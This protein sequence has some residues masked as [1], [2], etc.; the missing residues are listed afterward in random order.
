[1]DTY[2][3]PAT[4]VVPP[5]RETRYEEDLADGLL[6]ADEETFA[7]I[8]RRWGSLVHTMATRSLGD[9]HEAEDVTQQVFIGVWRG[10]HG[11]RPERGT[12]GAWLVGIT[13]RKI[14][15][16][17]A[18]RGRRLALVESAARDAAPARPDRQAPEEVLDR[19]L[20]VEALSRLPQ[21]QREV[22]C[23]AFYEDLTQA[24]IAERTGVPLGTV[25]SHTRR[26]LHRLRTVVVDLGGAHHPGG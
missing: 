9:T 4:T 5:V 20:L 18:A 16:A 22:L 6:R 23:M 10:R 8:Y 12:L 7:A 11:F 25:K 21:A 13:R 14:V 19:V 1:M 15:D 24:Q 3:R 2:A 17:L 26:G